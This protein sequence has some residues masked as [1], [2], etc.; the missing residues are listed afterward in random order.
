MVRANPLSRVEKQDRKHNKYTA[1]SSKEGKT[2]TLY[3][4]AYL[5][6]RPQ[7][8]ASHGTASHAH[9]TIKWNSSN[10]APGTPQQTRTCT[11]PADRTARYTHNNSNREHPHNVR[12]A[13]D[14]SLALR[15]QRCTT[16]THRPRGAHFNHRVTAKNIR[17][18]ASIYKYA[19]TQI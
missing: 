12:R 1:Q 4:A 9:A 15:R 11:K 2:F 3:I 16:S 18:A 5:L 17:T 19:R 10:N 13:H 8:P 14:E 7:W 6:Y